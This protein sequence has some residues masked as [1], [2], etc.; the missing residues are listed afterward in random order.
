MILAALLLCVGPAAAASQSAHD[1]CDKGSGNAAI[2][3]C[4]AIID[5][6]SEPARARAA[7]HVNRGYEW[8]IKGDLDRAI[9]DYSAAIAL[10]GRYA[11]AYHRRGMALHAK[12]DLD[13]ALADHTMAIRIEPTPATFTSR[14]DVWREKGDVDRAIVDYGEAIRLDATS[15]AAFHRRGLAWRQK[16]QI[17]RAISDHTSAIRLDPMH[18]N[19]YKH[20]GVAQ[21]EKGEF[22]GA[23]SDLLHAVEISDD[24]RMLLWRHIARG[25]IGQ[26]GT[27]E[28]AVGASRL[29]SKDWPFALIELYL[30][31]RTPEDIN[32]AAAMPAAKCEAAFYIGQWLVLQGNTPEARAAFQS[33]TELCPR[34]WI[35]HDVSVAELRRLPLPREPR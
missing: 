10:N 1:A 30:G 26:D 8:R 7:A 14:G 34:H 18:A 19:A 6:Q 2:T 29:T 25:R 35:E 20:R 12:G 13:R 9:V 33:A 17:D 15:V 4:T 5:D 22:L 21:F 27:T 28:L 11:A 3:G 24:A 23:A 32:A 31:K 16:D